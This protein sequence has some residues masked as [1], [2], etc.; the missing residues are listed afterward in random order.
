MLLAY[1]LVQNPV[2]QRQ[3]HI[4]DVRPRCYVFDV[5]F[6]IVS[7]FLGRESLIARASRDQAAQAVS[8]GN[9]QRYDVSRASYAFGSGTWHPEAIG[10]CNIRGGN[11]SGW[12]RIISALQIF[13]EPGA[14][15]QIPWIT[16]SW[17]FAF[18]PEDRV[19]DS[20]N[21]IV[22]CFDCPA[23]PAS[24]SEWRGSIP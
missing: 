22:H 17:A 3:I 21:E 6:G 20:G 10:I 11:W 18:L 5:R 4:W 2:P 12:L 13:R 15:S 8:L 14:I 1:R 9:M 7:V 19:G 16:R 24:I 23:I